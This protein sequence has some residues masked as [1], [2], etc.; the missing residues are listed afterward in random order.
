MTWTKQKSHSFPSLKTSR[1]FLRRLTYAD[2]EALFS[3]FSEP[4]VTEY[5]DVD[6]LIRVEQAE[7]LIRL[8][9]VA[10]SMK[11]AMRWALV[12]KESNEVIGTCGFHNFHEE[13]ARAEIGYDLKPAFW[14]QGYMREAV[15][16]MI[17][18]G[19]R[20]LNLHRIEAFIFPQNIASRK[21][22]EAVGL[23][24]EGRLQ[25]YFWHRGEFVDSEI[26]AITYSRWKK[27]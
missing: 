15:S 24:F 8:W 5:Y 1:L 20:R 25:E 21:L 6:T 12:L 7:E 14:H 19:F 10:Y 16:S 17:R 11:K 2:A 23:Q 4:S 18:Y 27:K 13:H 9:N 26:Y 3:Y 22:L